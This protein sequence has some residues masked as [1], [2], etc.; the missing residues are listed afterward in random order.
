MKESYSP[1]LPLAVSR[2]QSLTVAGVFLFIS[3]LFPQRTL[4]LSLDTNKP[5]VLNQSK[6]QLNQLNIKFQTKQQL[7]D[8]KTVKLKNEQKKVQAVV[9]TKE[10]LQDQVSNMQSQ[11]ADLQAQVAEKARIEALRI[12][13]IAAYAS[14]A[15]GNNYVGGNCTWYVKSLRPDI[16][17]NWGNANQWYA[18]A[19]SA[20]FKTGSLAKTGAVGVSFAGA[21]GHVVYVD[22]WH[23]DGTVTI[24]EMNYLG[25]YKTDTR[26][27]PASDFV[28]IYEKPVQT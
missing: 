22:A 16:G 7:I 10:S 1:P 27:A 28:Y 8:Q 25:L 6:V 15:A 3:F 2:R 20:G 14:D 11:V 18:S 5:S 21:L 26:V 4:A 13:T 24:T 12:V 19:K 23:E 9:E 17:N